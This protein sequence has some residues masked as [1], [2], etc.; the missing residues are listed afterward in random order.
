MEMRHSST[1]WGSLADGR[2]RWRRPHITFNSEIT[3]ATWN[4]TGCTPVLN[5]RSPTYHAPAQATSSDRFRLDR[6]STA[7]KLTFWGTRRNLNKFYDAAQRSSSE[8]SNAPRGGANTC[9]LLPIFQRLCRWPRHHLDYDLQ[10]SSRAGPYYKKAVDL[11]PN[12]PV[13]VSPGWHWA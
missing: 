8:R 10:Q 9:V 11:E 12:N 6:T 5:L 2:W 3:G 7:W 1:S 13:F 4:I